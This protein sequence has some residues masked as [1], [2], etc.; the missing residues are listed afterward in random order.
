MKKLFVLVTLFTTLQSGSL[1]AQRECNCRGAITQEEFSKDTA[2]FKKNFFEDQDD[3]KHT[4][5]IYLPKNYFKLFHFFLNATEGA[6]G[7]WVYFVSKET[8]IDLD[9]QSRDDQ[10]LFNIVAS[11]NG[12]PE[13]DKLKAFANSSQILSTGNTIELSTRRRQSASRITHEFIL[14]RSKIDIKTDSFRYKEQNPLPKYSQR[15][16]ICKNQLDQIYNLITG[17]SLGGVKFYFASYNE[18]KD[19]VRN[20]VP[21]Q[22]TLILAPVKNRNS[23][24]D[25]NALKS[26]LI[27][28]FGISAAEVYNHG[29]LCPNDCE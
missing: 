25:F 14:K 29:S 11:I 8:K 4:E 24:P 19:C 18:I 28:K 1:L 23:G 3:K 26:F 13:F 9:Q 15:L 12:K 16:F 17:L 2:N 7:L 22:L 6:D 10:V 20:Q 5:W 21:E 27:K